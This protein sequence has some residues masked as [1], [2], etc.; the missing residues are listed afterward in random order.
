MSTDLFRTRDHVPDFDE[1]VIQYQHLSA[2]TRSELP[3][4]ANIAYGHE[5]GQRLDL[6]FPASLS[7]E[8]SA[9]RG[10]HIFIHGGY[11]R[12][13]SKDDFS[14]VARTITQAGAIAVLLDYDLMP[15]VRLGDVVRQ[16]REAKTWVSQNIHRYGGDPSHLT[17][18]GHSAGAHLATFLFTEGEQMPPRGALL[19]GGVYDLRPLRQ[20]FLQPLLHLTDDEVR[21]LSP[22]NDRFQPRVD[23]VILYGERETR[24]FHAQA[25]C[26]AW[27]LKEAGCSVSLTA[28][29]GADHMSSVL[30]LGFPDRET[31]ARLFSLIAKHRPS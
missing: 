5:P 19:L 4:I 3:L 14:Y 1:K 26:L 9:R 15:T 30:D 20:S 8:D 17:V 21:D 10:V 23:S 16:V 11:W 28:L 18:S 6:L 7:K 29:V 2:K 22:L 27:R 13:F 12:M 25:A 31:G 24:P